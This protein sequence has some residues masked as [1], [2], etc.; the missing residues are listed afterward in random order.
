MRRRKEER[1]RERGGR[2]VRVEG[3]EEEARRYDR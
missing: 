2:K 1:K 3:E